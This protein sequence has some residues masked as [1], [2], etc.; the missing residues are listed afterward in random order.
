MTQ[1][2]GDRSQAE[3]GGS[4]PET[5][6]LPLQTVVFGHGDRDPEKIRATAAQVAQ[7]GMT[8]IAYAP[9]GPHIIGTRICLRGD[10]TRGL[11]NTQ[12]ARHGRPTSFL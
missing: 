3:Y 4:I 8:E 5:Y 12:E 7:L 9:A 1:V 11:N 6:R 2:T 10:R